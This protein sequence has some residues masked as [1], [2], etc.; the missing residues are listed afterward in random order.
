MTSR[1]SSA[2]GRCMRTDLFDFELPA[3]SIALRPARPRDSARL[4]VVQ[5]DG[6]LR[7]TAVTDLPN[8]L[9]A[10][11]VLVV[12]DTRVISAQLG[13]RPIRRAPYPTIDAI[14]IK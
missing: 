14:L 10:R 5:G 9:E 11:D 12:N 2:K 7:D 13:G 8:W 4:L 3:E 6:V 1:R